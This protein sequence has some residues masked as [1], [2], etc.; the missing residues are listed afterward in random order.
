MVQ[1]SEGLPEKKRKL[2]VFDMRDLRVVAWQGGYNRNCNA[3]GSPAKRNSNLQTP[4][5]RS[6][7]RHD[8][9][10]TMSYV[11]VRMLFKVLSTV[12]MKTI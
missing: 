11:F 2:Y 3:E 5:R 4:G 1:N 7:R 10:E 9:G 6:H 12:A 8:Y